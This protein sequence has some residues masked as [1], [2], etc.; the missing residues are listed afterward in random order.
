M[1]ALLVCIDGNFGA[2]SAICGFA[3]VGLG[4]AAVGRG[5]KG[6]LSRCL[7]KLKASPSVGLRWQAVFGFQ[8]DHGIGDD[9]QLVNRCGWKDLTDIKSS[10]LT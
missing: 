5:A 8:S 4:R 3:S 2:I 10:H 7:V 1:P 9:P 6:L